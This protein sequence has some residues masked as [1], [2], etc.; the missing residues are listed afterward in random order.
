MA[1]LTLCIPI[2]RWKFVLSEVRRVLRVGGRLEVI[3]D[4]LFFP[5]VL[6]RPSRDA[7]PSPPRRGRQ[8]TA[9]ASECISRSLPSSS[10]ISRNFSGKA[11]PD[12]PSPLRSPSKRHKRTPSDVEYST[13][14]AIAAHVESAFERMLSEKF[15]VSPHPHVFL[16]HV[17][18]DVFGGDCTRQTQNLELAVPSRELSERCE[19]AGIRAPFTAASLPM[20]TAPSTCS[21]KKSFAGDDGWGRLEKRAA[22]AAAASS[23]AVQIPPVRPHARKGSE[24][25]IDPRIIG[26]LSPKVRQLLFGDDLENEGE[27]RRAALPFQPPGLV[28][29]PST[30]LPCGPLELEMHACKHMNTLLGCRYALARHLAGQR[31]LEGR[32]LLSEKEVDDFLWDY[33]W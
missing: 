15:S 21:T 11:L 30:L 13:N 8:R 4:D 2:S 26:A 16:D 7:P 31:D 10:P 19:S 22:A 5:T 6:P 12:I 20:P 1:N 29:L 23:F 18:R 32:R 28:L 25:G 27:A 17:L 9:S 24:D 33:E 14:S 3:D